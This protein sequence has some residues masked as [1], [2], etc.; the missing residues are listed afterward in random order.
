MHLDK[1]VRKGLP[2]S[3]PRNLNAS[4]TPAGIRTPGGLAKNK[5]LS[6]T[7]SVCEPGTLESCGEFAFV[8][9]SQVRPEPLGTR[10]NTPPEHC[11]GQE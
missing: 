6:P 7:P 11:A 10:K 8:E 5:L 1:V 3:E 9:S 4:P 2:E